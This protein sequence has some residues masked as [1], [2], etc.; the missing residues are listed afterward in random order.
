MLHANKGYLQIS[1]LKR[2]NIQVKKFNSGLLFAIRF[3]SSERNITRGCRTH[4]FTKKKLKIKME[5]HITEKSPS[6]FIGKLC[7]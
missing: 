2:E 3:T 7:C 5:A 1:T 4:Y 6:R